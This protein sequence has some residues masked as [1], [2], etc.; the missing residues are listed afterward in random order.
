MGRAFLIISVWFVNLSCAG[1]FGPSRETAIRDAIDQ[2][3]ETMRV[4]VPDI[5][6]P[7]PY[8]YSGAGSCALAPG[9]NS[10]RET[11]RYQA[12]VPLP[13]GD[14]GAERQR[15]AIQH[16][17][18]KGAKP[19]QL[20]NKTSAAEVEYQGGKIHAFAMPTR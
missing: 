10:T 20:P 17:I 12:E 5:D 13:A 9:L 4:A 3:K 8:K 2:S 11:L 1:P 16:W 15:R 6:H 18:D 7:E 19:R 14:D